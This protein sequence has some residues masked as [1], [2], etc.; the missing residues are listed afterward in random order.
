MADKVQVEETDIHELKL[1]RSNANKGT[2]RGRGVLELSLRQFG[3]A[4]AGTLDRNN[5]ILNGNKRTEV[6]ADLDMTE[7]IIVDIDGTKPVYLRRRDLDLNDP[8]DDS[9]RQLAYM[10]NRSAQ[11]SLDWDAAQLALDVA[12]GIDLAGM[13][14]EAEL[15]ALTKETEIPATVP[16]PQ[17]APKLTG[18][19][20]VEIYC[21]AQ[22]LE[23]FQVTLAQWEQRAG[24]VINI[25]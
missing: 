15:E 17:A 23:A 24:V 3:F 8:D 9:A 6:A 18:E 20:L 21:S 5:I 25:T 10:L 12:N 2:E 1:D 14:T 11:L 16:D 13:F 22:D 19:H 4:D 7:V